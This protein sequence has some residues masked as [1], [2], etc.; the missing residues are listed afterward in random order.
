MGTL[1]LV[2]HLHFDPVQLV[3]LLLHAPLDVIKHPTAMR[4]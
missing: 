3:V 1:L 2:L 4:I